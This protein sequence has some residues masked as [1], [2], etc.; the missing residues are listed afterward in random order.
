[1]SNNNVNLR[2]NVFGEILS[3]LNKYRIRREM[4]N[5]G[6]DGYYAILS[7]TSPNPY[8]GDVLGPESEI[9]EDVINIVKALKNIVFN[10]NKNNLYD[11][12]GL[13]L[14]NLYLT[15]I[16]KLLFQLILILKQYK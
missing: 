12:T 1:M 2:E 7:Q 8:G 15:D 13:I 11:Q 3:I 14:F 5:D 9:Q 16:I 4:N 6:N 10:F